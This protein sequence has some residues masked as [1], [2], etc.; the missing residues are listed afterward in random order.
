LYYPTYYEGLEA[1]PNIFYTAQEATQQNMAAVEWLIKNQGKKTFYLIGSDYIWPRTSNKIAKATIKKLGGK[2]LAEEYYPL[3][4]TQ[5]GSVI[6]KMKF[7]K[8]DVILSTVVGGSNVSFYKQLK[9]AGLSGEKATIMALAV[10]EEEVRA[11]G[12]QN[13][14][15]VYTSMGYFQSLDNA[16]NKKFVADFKAKYG[17]DRVI[18]DVMECAYISPYLWKMAVEKAGSFDVEK[19]AAAMADIE[20]D[21]PEGKIKVHGKNHH[22]YKYSRIGRI[23]PDGQVKVLYE[24]ELI[25]PNPFPKL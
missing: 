25:E 16:A 19:V 5:F 8:P 23:Q 22:L 1:S 9:A 6:N 2:V 24:T 3:G 20:F 14:A 17:K 21:A 10:S 18:G 4:H 13:V 11:I 12:P 15:G 7:K